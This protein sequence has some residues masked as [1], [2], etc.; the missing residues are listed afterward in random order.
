M[1]KFWCIPFMMLIWAACSEPV[2]TPIPNPGYA[3]FPVDT[4]RYVVYKVDS[5]YHDQ[6][7]VTIPG[8]HDTSHYF[9]KE[10]IDSEFLDAQNEKSQ[11]I[12]RYKRARQTDDWVL[13]DVWYAKRNP[14]NAERVEENRRYVKMGFPI[15]SFS[16][17]NGNA[18]NN[19]EQW[20]YEYDSLY[21]SKSYGDLAFAK[22]V[23]VFQRDFLTEVNDQYAYEVYAENVGLVF[24]YYKNLFTRPSYLNNRI[25]KNIISGNEF[26]WQ[27]VDYGIE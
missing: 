10:V 3:Y 5:I 16:T 7:D 8:I 11:R 14:N 27:I 21:I 18:L 24:R 6:P 17:W 2:N 22:T 19:L 9:L 15:N 26:T 4:G 12:L 20:R 23:T 1:R 13:T 25:A